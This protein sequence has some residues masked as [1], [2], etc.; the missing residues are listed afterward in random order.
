MFMESRNLIVSSSVKNMLAAIVL[1]VLFLAPAVTPVMALSPNYVDVDVTTAFDMMRSGNPSLVIIDVRPYNDYKTTHLPDAISLPFEELEARV[2]EISQVDDPVLLVYCKTGNT[3][4]MAS[5]LLVQLGFDNV[6]NML[7]GIVDWIASG[8]PVY[9]TS[10]HVSVGPGYSMDIEPMLII[11]SV[12]SSCEYNQNCSSGNDSIQIES[13]ILEDNDNHKVTDLLIVVANESY[14]YVIV[15]TRLW[16]LEEVSD[17]ATRTTS[18]FTTEITGSDSSTY[19][20][21]TLKYSVQ[22]VDYNFTLETILT[23]LNL[24]SYNHSFTIARFKSVAETET[25]S[26]EFVESS[27]GTRLSKMYKGLSKAIK[28]LGKVY[29]DYGLE[30]LATNYY[31]LE[32][33]LNHVSILVRA[34]LGEFD[35]TIL[36]SRAFLVDDWFSCW[37]LCLI[38]WDFLCSMA[39]GAACALF[40]P[41]CTYLIV[42]LSAGCPAAVTIMCEDWGYCP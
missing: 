16:S 35:K 2:T 6:F 40:T 7:G 37:V 28:N 12:C 18:F 10:H 11:Q 32:N 1:I 22:H 34:Q 36:A 27:S 9:T 24:D 4:Q 3:S 33:E 21:N 8:Y 25:N 17:Y 26:V 5:E 19:Q 29:D 15:S 31:A 41:F 30:Q 14:E 39:C 38:P 20:Y 23:P 42:C 13:T